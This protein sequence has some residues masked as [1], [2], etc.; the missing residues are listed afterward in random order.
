MSYFVQALKKDILPH[1]Q[2]SLSQVPFYHIVIINI[3]IIIINA[4]LFSFSLS[5]PI[6]L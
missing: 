3:I 4:A 5:L 2:K 6:F 1:L